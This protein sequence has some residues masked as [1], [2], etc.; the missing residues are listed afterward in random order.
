[1]RLF[2]LPYAGGGTSPYHGWETELPSWVEACSLRLPGRESRIREEP[3]RHYRPLADEIAGAIKRRLDLPYAMFGHS[4]GAFLA[5]EVARRIRDN[6]GPEPVHLFVSARGAPQLPDKDPPIHELPDDEFIDELRRHQGTPPAV[7]ESPE[8]MQL[9]MPALRADFAVCD[10]YEFRPGPPLRCP[11]SAFG[12][13]G[14]PEVSR[15]QLQAW[16]EQTTGP[17]V[18]RT[19]P[20]GHFFLQSETSQLLRILARELTA[21]AD[22]GA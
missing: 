6:A 18:V 13:L 22:G 20:G 9:V 17:F 14:D 7:L 4:M 12:G 10:S 15:T 19:F 21:R 5:F 11:I 1:L 16:K 8:L 2:C 3:L